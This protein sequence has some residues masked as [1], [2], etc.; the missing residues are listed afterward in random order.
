MLVAYLPDRKMLIEADLFDSF[1]PN[2]GNAS[3]ANRSLFNHV[4]HLALDVETIAPIQGEP[5]TWED[6]VSILD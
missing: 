3:D 5:T 6:F 4:Q 2:I 1:E